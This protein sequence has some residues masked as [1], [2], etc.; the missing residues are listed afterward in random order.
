MVVVCNMNIAAME[1]E[2]Q[3]R[4]RHRVQVGVE[5][6]EEELAVALIH[7]QNCLHHHQE[8]GSVRHHGALV[9]V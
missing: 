1:E 5:E 4:H 3:F 8:G 7:N 9:L 6:E 2:D